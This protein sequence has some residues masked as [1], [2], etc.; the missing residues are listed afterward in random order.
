[1]VEGLGA[2][3]H[4]VQCM[5]DIEQDTKLQHANGSVACLNRVLPEIVGKES[6]AEFL[7]LR[8]DWEGIRNGNPLP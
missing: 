3:W 1:M 7:A 5:E 2:I 4:Q 8:E 6:E